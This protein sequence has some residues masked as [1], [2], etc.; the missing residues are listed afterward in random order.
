MCKLAGPIWNG[1]IEF[2][3]Q[4]GNYNW[5]ESYLL[6]THR[7]MWKKIGAFLDQEENGTKQ[8]GTNFDMEEMFEHGKNLNASKYE[9][10]LFR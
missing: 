7:R 2:R 6:F 10:N 3:N 9:E 4:G 5:T 8:S 1:T